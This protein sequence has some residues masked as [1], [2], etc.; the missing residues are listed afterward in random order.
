MSRYPLQDSPRGIL[1][2]VKLLGNLLP[3]RGNVVALRGKDSWDWT[4]GAAT[5][6]NRISPV[7]RK[8]GQGWN[9][10]ARVASSFRILGVALLEDREEAVSAGAWMG[11]C[12]TPERVAVQKD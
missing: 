11:G 3:T 9:D 6:S 8:V 2:T 12:V 4:L 10:L 7:G 5:T 1:G